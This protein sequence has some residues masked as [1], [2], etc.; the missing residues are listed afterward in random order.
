MVAGTAAQI[1]SDLDPAAWQRISS[2]Q[3]TKGERFHDRA[4][5][6][7][8]D[9]EADEYAEGAAGTWTRRLTEHRR[10]LAECQVGGDDDRGAL[11]ELAGE[12][13]QQLAA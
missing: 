13:E 6:E 5:F 4:Y 2:G 1:A 7:L 10:Q 11:V 8:A 9:L 12:V 3:D